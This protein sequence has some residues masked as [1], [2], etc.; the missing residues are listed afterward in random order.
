MIKLL[1]FSNITII[2]ILALF[3]MRKKFRE[4]REESAH[5]TKED[6]FYEPLDIEKEIL[7][8]EEEKELR[9]PYIITLW[10]GFDGLR[11]NEDGS[12]EWTDRRPKKQE[13]PLS[14][15]DHSEDWSVDDI[16]RIKL[17]A[18]RLNFEHEHK[19]LC[20]K[21]DLTRCC[22]EEQYEM[23]SLPIL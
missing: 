3:I 7:K 14:G 22:C 10:L 9:E 15:S 19:L 16:I 12:Y 20:D 2:F 23:V 8:I 13:E 1:F 4:P 18:A 21:Y 6:I 17:L 11:I 5:K